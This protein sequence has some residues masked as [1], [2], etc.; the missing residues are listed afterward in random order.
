MCL[1][2]FLGETLFHAQIITFLHDLIE[3]YV[4]IYLSDCPFWVVT[5]RLLKLPMS[6]HEHKHAYIY[7]YTL[8][9]TVKISIH[10]T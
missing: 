3:T 10:D 8:A 9:S 7:W 4:S 2:T 6:V 5:I 1:S